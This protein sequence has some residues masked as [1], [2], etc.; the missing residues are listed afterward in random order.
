MRPCTII[1]CFHGS[2]YL[3][4]LMC[5]WFTHDADMGSC[6]SKHPGLSQV[7]P[8]P[9]CPFCTSSQPPV[10]L[11]QWEAKGQCSP[12]SPDV[13]QKANGYIIIFSFSQHIVSIHFSHSPL[14]QVRG[15]DW[16]CHMAHSAKC[17]VC[18]GPLDTR[19]AD[20]R[21]S[22]CYLAW[23]ACVLWVMPRLLKSHTRRKM[24]SC[25]P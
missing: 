11:M 1:A 17:C 6:T 2:G 21:C 25:D 13:V 5:I 20:G 4:L 24:F 16:W 12:F 9:W 7:S 23:P 22:I 3:P 19:S 14:W 15:R 10:H 8:V 18:T